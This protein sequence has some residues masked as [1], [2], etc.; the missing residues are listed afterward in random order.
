MPNVLESDLYAPVKAYLEDCGFEVRAEV[1]KC[2]VVACR[3]Q[4]V[5]A[6]EM[7]L[8]FGTPVLY[9]ALERLAAVDFVYVAVSVAD[10]AKARANWDAQVKPAVRLC[11]MLGVGL[12]SVRDGLVVVHTDP[13]VYEPRKQPRQRSK[14]L[15]EF[16]GR[17]GDHNVGGTTKRP[18][19]TVYREKAL[20][21]AEILGDG[22]VMQ[23]ATVRKATGHKNAANILRDNVYGWFIKQPERGMYS[24]SPAGMNALAQ[25]AD[26]L[27]AQR[28][29]RGAPEPVRLA[30]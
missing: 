18:R 15:G 3:D 21:C 29:K 16:Q 13:A 20:R 30:A 1:G 10:G 22:E 11:R 9:Q 4:T 27:A 8:A 2:D 5:V 14:L 19:V 17:S 12:L 6:V 24:V 25:Y 28:R 26:V 23:A 7:K